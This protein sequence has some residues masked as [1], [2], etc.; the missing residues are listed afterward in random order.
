MTRIDRSVSMSR[1]VAGA[2][3]ASLSISL[4]A[5]AQSSSV[6]HLESSAT[7]SAGPRGDCGPG[8]AA[9][10]QLHHRQR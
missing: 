7:A 1:L 9:R 6:A 10:R 3:L 5:Q 4:W 8:E 2:V